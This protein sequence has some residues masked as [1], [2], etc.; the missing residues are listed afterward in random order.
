M[1]NDLL[2]FIAQWG[3]LMFKVHRDRRSCEDNGNVHHGVLYANATMWP[4][5]KED[6]VLWV[7]VCETFGIE[8]A[9]W[10]DGLRFRIN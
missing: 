2:D 8:P 5:S 6:V 9:V 7:L 3:N 10:V 1:I 4:A